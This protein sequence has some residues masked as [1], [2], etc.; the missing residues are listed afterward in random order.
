MIKNLKIKKFLYKYLFNTQIDIVNKAVSDN[1]GFL[2]LN[3]T[4]NSQSSSILKLKEQVI[5]SKY[6]RNKKI[7]IES[8]TLNKEFRKSLIL[9]I[10]IGLHLRI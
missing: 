7:K 2:D 1:I 8:T 3:V 10:L 6:K 9:M 5:I 4:S